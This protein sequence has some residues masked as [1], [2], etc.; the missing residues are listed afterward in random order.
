MESQT[1]DR[2]QQSSRVVID[3]SLVDDEKRWAKRFLLLQEFQKL[4]FAFAFCE[5]Y[6]CRI[7]CQ[8]SR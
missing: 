3:R 5:L 8:I 2:N 4:K 6:K 1:V 7:G